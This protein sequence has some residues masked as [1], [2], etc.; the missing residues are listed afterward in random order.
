MKM[1]A[2]QQEI[3]KGKEVVFDDEDRLY[4]CPICHKEYKNR[5]HANKHLDKKDCY[6]VQ[7][8]VYGYPI[9]TTMYRVYGIF[10]ET[11][12][13]SLEDF[14][15]S[16]FYEGVA[17]FCAH[18]IDLSIEPTN[19]AT[20]LKTKLADWR[21]FMILNTGLGD[22]FITIYRTFLIRNP[23]FIDSEGYYNTHKQKFDTL[24]FIT[25]SLERALVS[26]DYLKQTIDSE[27]MREM[28]RQAPF[29][30]RMMF[31]TFINMTGQ[32]HAL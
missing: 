23:S 24:S 14:R 31:D 6:S 2:T 7:D 3:F 27:R 17:K 26:W 21:P 8:M 16:R 18:C 13:S 30:D 11:D 5:N 20:F 10:F 4:R 19:Y 28:Y 9:E 1:Y 32:R 29:A 15:K 25:F 22:D 12:R